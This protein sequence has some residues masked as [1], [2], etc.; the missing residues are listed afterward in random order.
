MSNWAMPSI[1]VISMSYARPFTAE[2]FPIFE[3]IV[4]AGLEFCELLV[5]EPGELDPAEA[6]AAAQG[7]GLDLVLAARVNL[8]RDLA[9][10]DAD[11]H[12]AG[13]AYLKYCVDVAVACGAKIVGGPLYGAPLVF[14][15]RAPAPI[16]DDHRIERVLRVMAGL[17]D[18]G[19]YAFDNG[20]KR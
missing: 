13:I 5:P 6:A 17:Q 11:S 20:V 16:D 15:G 4:N 8:S 1:G 19:A 12:A 10:D 18:A 2:H 3:R 7:A 9:S 14:A